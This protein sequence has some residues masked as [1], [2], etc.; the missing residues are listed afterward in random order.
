MKEALK[1]VR[2]A[3]LLD[4]LS[5][6]TAYWH[7]RYLLY[8]RQIDEAIEEGQRALGL[9]PDYV[10]GMAIL[11]RAELLRGKSEAAI[12]F[13]RRCV[14]LARSN[15]FRA[16]LAYGLASAG[17]DAEA[18]KILGEIGHGEDLDYVR[19]ELLAAVHGALGETDEAFRELER[20]YAARSAGLIYLHLDP[21]Y[22]S[23][24]GDPRMDEMVQRIGL[25]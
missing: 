12:D 14:D 16:Y 9:D 20:A 22:D 4:P 8:S 24:R 3:Q 5:P 10:Y 11:G 2:A 19:S 7:A 15:T 6:V 1:E 13:F 21:L 17:R 25:Q 23:L 18:R